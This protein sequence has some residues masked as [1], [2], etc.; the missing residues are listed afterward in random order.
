MSSRQRYAIIGI[1]A[2]A[3]LVAVSLS[4]GLRWIWAEAGWD[5]MPVLSRELP[6]TSLI[7]YVSAAVAAL[8]AVKHNHTF[9]LATEVVDELSKVTW[10]S[11]EE[12]GNATVVV[13]VT[14]LL[15]SVFLGIF[16][17]LWLWLTNLVLGV[18]GS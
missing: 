5:D 8:V 11:R 15:S 1:L 18:P 6:L 14:V 3:V 2:L 16:D 10:P 17:A 13:I 9:Q 7:A 12:T 4:H